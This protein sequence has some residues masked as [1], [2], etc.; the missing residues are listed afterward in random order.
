MLFSLVKK[1]YASAEYLEKYGEPQT[2]EDL[3]QHRM[4]AFGHPEVHPYADIN[5]ILKL[6][7]PEGK[8]HEP[9]FTSN[10]VECMIEAAKKGLGIV[11]SYQEMK[12]VKESKLKNILPTVTDKELKNYIIYPDYLKNDKEVIELKKYLYKM[13]S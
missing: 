4:I 6:G 13:L 5:W 9:I 12:I 10:S 1:L 3:K 11:G 7:M 8:L 2:V